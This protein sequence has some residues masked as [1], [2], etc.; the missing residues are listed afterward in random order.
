MIGHSYFLA[1]NITELKMKLDYEIKPILREYVK[2]GILFGDDISLI[3]ENLQA[4]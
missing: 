2:D 1:Q 3:I 4:N